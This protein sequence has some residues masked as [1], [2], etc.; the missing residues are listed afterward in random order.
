MEK[1]K[2]V[3]Y[4]ESNWN[5]TVKES[6]EDV[7]NLIGLPYPYTVPATGFFDEM[8]Y[9]D[10]YFTNC[11]L[12]ISDK[13]NL[14][15]SNTDN[16]LFLV[17]KY[18]FMPNG[19]RTFYLGN[20]HP[21]F[22]SEMVKK[23]F[24]KFNDLVWLNG[25]YSALC[26]EY[27]FW[28]TKRITKTGLNQYQG[29][30]VDKSE[31]VKASDFCRR[32][33][34]QPAD[35]TKQQLIDHYLICCESGWDITPRWG[36]EGWEY[37]QIDLNSLLFLMEKNMAYFSLKLKNGA[38]NVWNDRAEERK[39][40]IIKYMDNNGLF[41]DYNFVNESF[42]KIFSVA[43]LYPMFVNMADELQAKETV[44]NLYRLE[45]E[46]GLCACE[47]NNFPG[48]M[49]WNWPMGN[50]CL[51]FIAV[52]ALDNYG[53]K[54]DAKRIA[55]KHTKLIEKVFDETGSLW[56]NYNVVEGNIN[57]TRRSTMPSMMGRTAGIYL[58]L[59]Q[60]TEAGKI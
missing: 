19:N 44:K 17:K 60:Y 5:G 37:V 24:E 53:Y 57:V 25:A 2:V 22:L 15:K 59:K 40:L 49:R 14:V 12:A 23:V 26:A 29:K 50:G 13:W 45:A 4:I 54:E 55:E 58:A 6:I 38:E 20:S 46:Y 1:N 34:Y 31:N 21:P 30:N 27:E 41:Y 32:I 47:K 43:S 42:G 11:G 36:F 33:Q 7:G 48:D 18:G 56:E 10:T 39:S 9:W 51:Q 16:M 35:K 52:K 8:Y 3:E 28:Q